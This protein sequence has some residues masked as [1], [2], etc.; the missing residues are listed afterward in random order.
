MEFKK[1]FEEVYDKYLKKEITEDSSELKKI[2]PEIISVDSELESLMEEKIYKAK[3]LKDIKLI[4]K[5][6]IYNKYFPFF[7][8]QDSIFLDNYRISTSFDYL[9]KVWDI[10]IDIQRNIEKISN[11]SKILQKVFTERGL[12]FTINSKF[13]LI[14]KNENLEVFRY[15][16]EREGSSTKEVIFYIEKNVKNEDPNYGKTLVFFGNEYHNLNNFLKEVDF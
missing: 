2:I 16:F 11:K 5:L 6:P 10:K 3:E 12:E 15:I 1:E 7:F 9:N 8:I 14:Y 4:I 13:K